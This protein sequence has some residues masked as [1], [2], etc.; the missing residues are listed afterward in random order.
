MAKCHECKSIFTHGHNWNY[1]SSLHAI[2]FFLLLFFRSGD[3]CPYEKRPINVLSLFDGISTGLHILRE[4]LGLKIGWYFS[5]EID[6]DALKVQCTRFRDEMVALGCVKKIT[7][8]LLD[9][10]GPIDLLIGE[11]HAMNESCESTQKRLKFT[12]KTGLGKSRRICR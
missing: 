4:R 8:E 9:A 2:W 6:P 10:L 7:P 11:A 1:E 5:S 3:S 12:V